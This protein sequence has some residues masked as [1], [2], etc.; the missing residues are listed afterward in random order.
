MPISKEEL[1]RRLRK[2]DFP[3]IGGVTPMPSSR[4]LFDKHHEVSPNVRIYFEDGSFI[5]GPIKQEKK[6]E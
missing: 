2:D 4:E 1:K 3:H 5:D 6:D